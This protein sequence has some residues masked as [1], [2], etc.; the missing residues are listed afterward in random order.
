MSCVRW[1]MRSTISPPKVFTVRSNSEMWRVIS[2]PSVPLSRANFSA[3]SPPWFFT[4]SS[5]ALICSDSVSCAVS[6]WL[7]TLATSEFTVT[8]SASLALSPRVRIWVARRLPA[9]SILLTR[10][11]LR[12]SS[13]SSSESLEFF[14]ESWTCSVRSEM[15]STMVEERCS[16]SLVMRSMPLVQHLVDAVGEI[17]ELVMDVAGLEIEAG[18]EPL[19][20]V[21]HRA[22]GLGAG[23]LEAVEQVAAALAERQDHVVA[24]IGERAR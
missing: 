20:G 15:P 8:S 9:S 13:S 4:S 23:F 16:N 22:R 14:R 21:E 12:S 24:G 17:D 11:P 7:T 3:S 2:A 1:P 10:S 6:V 18:G 19:A 5:K